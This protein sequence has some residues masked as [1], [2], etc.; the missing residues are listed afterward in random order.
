MFVEEYRG[1]EIWTSGTGYIYVKGN[2]E[3]SVFDSMRDVKSA[4][5]IITY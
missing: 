2:L 4:I 5:D 3:S 1:Y